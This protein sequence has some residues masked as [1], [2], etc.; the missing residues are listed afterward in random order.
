MQRKIYRIRNTRPAREYILAQRYRLIHSI[1]VSNYKKT[2]EF[3]LK[4]KKSIQ[5]DR[6][7]YNT[8]ARFLTSYTSYFA[9][10]FRGFE[11]KGN[12]ENNF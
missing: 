3:S 2:R 9:L 12:K 1:G 8:K 10:V 7:Q 11:K 4:F 6:L 5:L